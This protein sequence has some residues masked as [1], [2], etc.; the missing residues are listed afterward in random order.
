MNEL[1][2]QLDGCRS[3]TEFFITVCK[4]KVAADFEDLRRLLSLMDEYIPKYGG[5]A[6]VYL[7]DCI[8]TEIVLPCKSKEAITQ[9]EKAMQ[10][11][12]VN[13]F[14]TLFPKYT[15]VCTEKK[16]GGIGRIDIFALCGKRPVIIEL[17]VR[18]KNPAGQL[19]AYATKFENPI[20]IGITQKPIREENKIDGIKYMLFD[21]LKRGVKQWII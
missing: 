16:V 13:N 6:V 10:S 1:K 2:E 4:I 18:S 20:L 11:E 21:E 19:L 3:F 9:L 17:K 15:F 5:D 12:I 7:K 14:N 8:Q